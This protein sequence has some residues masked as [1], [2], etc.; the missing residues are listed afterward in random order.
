M[1]FSYGRTPWSLSLIASAFLRKV[2]K[3][4]ICQQSLL[5]V[6]TS[7]LVSAE[8]TWGLVE[9]QVGKASQVGLSG[10]VAQGPCFLSIGQDKQKSLSPEACEADSW[11][12][13]EECHHFGHLE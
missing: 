9:A 11:V 8:I 7:S 13:C 3:S 1:W 4:S 10:A 2:C 6:L 12:S 5:E